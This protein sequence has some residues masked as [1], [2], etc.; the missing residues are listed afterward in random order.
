[1]YTNQTLSHW[2]QITTLLSTCYLSPV[3]LLASNH[4]LLCATVL[5][6]PLWARLGTPLSTIST[7]GLTGH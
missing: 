4:Y 7:T 2:V 1:M 6:S 5:Q 3:L